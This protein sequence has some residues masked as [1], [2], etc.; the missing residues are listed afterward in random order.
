MNKLK[1]L[2]DY[3]NEKIRVSLLNRSNFI[4]VDNMLQNKGGIVE[5]DYIQEYGYATK[6][7]SGDILVGNIRPYLRKIWLADFDGGCSAD[8]LCIRSKGK[9]SSKYIFACLCQDSF[10][11]FVMKGS[12]GTK[13][14]R[15]DKNRIMEYPL[16][17]SVQNK[18]EIGEFIFEINKKIRINNEIN[19][20]LQQLLSTIVNKYLSN[21][22]TKKHIKLK[23]LL[24][25]INDSPIESY[26]ADIPTI[27]LS[28]MPS[29]SFSLTELNI[30]SQ[31]ETNLFKMKEGNLLFGSIRPYLKKAGIA[32]CNGAVAGTV[33]QYAVIDDKFYNL[34]LYFLTNNQIFEFA[35]KS[36]HGTKMPVINSD[37]LLE[38]PI[39][40][41]DELLSCISNIKIKE[42]IINNCKEIIKLSKIRDFLLP[43]LM[44][45]QATISD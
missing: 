20:N 36:S 38:Y 26:D 10:F 44:N 13:M 31:F 45:G 35:T 37:V 17:E 25:R 6:F 15:G 1:D 16:L 5:S 7:Q 14:P 18:N 34:V 27:D 40:Y 22:K 12:K 2:C 11:D 8:V 30:S 19:D 29:N 4:G 33:Y 3:V 23:D 39:E 28:V 42:I 9:V 21:S 41:T 32:P 24:R 43:L